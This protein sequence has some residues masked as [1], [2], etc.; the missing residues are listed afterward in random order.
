MQRFAALRFMD[1]FGKIFVTN[2]LGAGCTNGFSL[3]ALPKK[4]TNTNQKEKAQEPCARRRDFCFGNTENVPNMRDKTKSPEFLINQ[5]KSRLFAWRAARD[6]NPDLLVRSQTLYPTELAA[7][8]RVQA[9]AFNRPNIIPPN[10]TNVNKFLHD[11]F[12]S[13]SFYAGFVCSWVR[14]G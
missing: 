7:Q 3:S 9:I 14:N 5:G 2:G 1:C 10:E 6:S 11:F 13:K 4:F 8:M 12:K